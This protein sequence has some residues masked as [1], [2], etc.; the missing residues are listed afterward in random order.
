MIH[1]VPMQLL[2]LKWPCTGGK[3]H[4]KVLNIP[5][6]L[7]PPSNMSFKSTLFSFLGLADFPGAVRERFQMRKDILCPSQSDP[8]FHCL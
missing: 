6:C 5:T 4:T 7:L 8:E 3:G 2:L 1:Y